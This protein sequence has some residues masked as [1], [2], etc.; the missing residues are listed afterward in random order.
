M[1]MLMAFL[2]AG[3]ARAQGGFVSGSTGADG[4]FNP[5]TN[6]A[7]Q[8]PPSGIFNF[9]TVNI[10]SGVTITFI[11]NATNTPVTILATGNITIAGTIDVSGQPGITVLTG[12]AGG[13]GGH[14]GG[15]GAL[16]ITGFTVGQ[17]GDGP[18]GGTGGNDNGGITNSGGGGG[19]HALAGANGN[20]L[21]GGEGGPA[22]G[23]RTLLPLL[24]GSGGGG[25]GRVP[26]NGPFGSG[27][28]GG[29]AILLASSGSIVFSPGAQILASGGGVGVNHPGGGGSGGAI[30]LISNTISGFVTL[31]VSGGFSISRG[32]PGFVRVEAFDIS[33]F[34]PDIP[35]A[36]ASLAL[37]QSVMLPPTDPRLRVTS[38]AG[39]APPASPAGSFLGVPDITL[40]LSQPNPVTVALEAQNVPVGTV[41]DVTLTPE[42]G[43]RTMAQSTPLSGTA[44]LSTAT[45]SLTIPDGVSVINATVVIN[46]NP[47]NPTKGAS[48]LPMYVDGERVTRMEVSTT[49]GGASQMV[50]V[51]QSGRRVNSLIR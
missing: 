16:A 6:Q 46:L 36:I 20:G 47:S 8:L 29:G 19:G 22:Y 25:P 42:A 4:A 49:Y 37:P 43:P 44:A 40:P 39:I 48:L 21:D 9:T 31:N 13:P 1:I 15:N 51:T 18:G 17:P 3:T 2:T 7:V 12:G 27:G 41:V 33:Q 32:S 23:S 45:A 24:G 28:G 50:Y 38:V 26:G 14:R 35:S 5:T 30:R 34:D 10:P 11:R